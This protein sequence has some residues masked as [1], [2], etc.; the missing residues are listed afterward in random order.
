MPSSPTTTLSR[1]TLLLPYTSLT[2]RNPHH[3]T[4]LWLS[5]NWAGHQQAI[6]SPTNCFVLT[7][8]ANTTNKPAKIRNSSFNAYLVDTKYSGEY[9]YAN[10]WFPCL[11]IYNISI[12]INFNIS[13]ISLE[14][15]CDSCI[16]HFIIKIS[17]LLK[18]SMLIII[19]HLITL[20]IQEFAPL[21][22]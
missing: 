18:N 10:H 1:T 17:L 3:K 5:V 7:I 8:S 21:I 15:I 14:I 22:L 19:I 13:Q 11:L 20:Y 2:T 6:G 4:C 16:S 12:A 9:E